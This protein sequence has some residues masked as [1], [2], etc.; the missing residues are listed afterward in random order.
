MLFPVRFT[1]SFGAA[2]RHSIRTLIFSALLASL[3]HGGHS[4][5]AQSLSLDEAMQLAQTG[6]PLLSGQGASIQATEQTALAATQLPDPK[7][8]LGV[9]NLPLSGAEAFTI[10]QDFMTMRMIGVMQEFPRAEKRRLRGQLAQ[11][12][13][14]QK[15]LELEFLKRTIR[16]DAGIAWLNVWYA[17]RAG[18]RVRAQRL[19]TATRIEALEIGLRS[20]RATAGEVAGAR[21]EFELLGDREAEYSRQAA[22]A[23]ADLARWIGEAAQRPLP[24]QAPSLPPG[25]ELGRLLEHLVRH[26]HLAAFAVQ[27][28]ISETDAR[29]AQQATR[30][31]W[32]VEVSYAQRG[33]AYSDMVSVQFGID[34]PLFAANRQDRLAHSKL[35]EADRARALQDDNLRQMRSDLMRFAAEHDAAIGRAA[36]FRDRVLP[37]AQSRLEAESASYRAGK[38]SL[39]A[40]LEARRS[41]LELQVESLM[42]EAEAARSRLQ[43]MYFFPEEDRP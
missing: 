22:M 1:L 28:R 40:V 7:L 12:D 6:Q 23:R 31:D 29:L 43:L 17:E 35:L 4:V 9:L 16:R 11:L 37:Q 27:T 34:L 41:L 19:E 39:N 10:G 33:A 13:G 5:A 21:V 15:T 36:M 20:G 32:S 14:E 30:P 24:T 18:E 38:V 2:F 3:P 8:R 42:R 25:P 26:P